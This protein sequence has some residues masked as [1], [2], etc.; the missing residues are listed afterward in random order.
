MIRYCQ[1]L[2]NHLDPL[3][4]DVSASWIFP[5]HSVTGLSDEGEDDE[6]EEDEKY[7]HSAFV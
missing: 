7:R 6:E 5:L 1:Y 2:Y 4:A 3:G